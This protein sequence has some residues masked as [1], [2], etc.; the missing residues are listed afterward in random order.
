MGKRT[1]IL[2][3]FIAASLAFTGCSNTES[4]P[5]DEVTSAP[6]NIVSTPNVTSSPSPSHAGDEVTVEGPGSSNVAVDET[7]EIAS[8]TDGATLKYPAGT[9]VLLKAG[10]PTKWTVASMSDVAKMESISSNNAAGYELAVK[11]GSGSGSIGI[12]H[13]DSSSMITVNVIGS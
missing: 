9:V 10:D 7:V 6:S 3:G 12:M 2:A 4:K 5:G 11:I 13:A 8:L 1:L